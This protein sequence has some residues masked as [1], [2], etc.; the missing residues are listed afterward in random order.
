MENSLSIKKRVQNGETVNFS[1][2]RDI[3]HIWF[4]ER[5]KDFCLMLNSKVIK[6]T[7]T[8]KPVENKFNSIEP[9]LFEVDDE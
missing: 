9:E 8:F 1:N 6:A 3:V 7:K 4:S 2:D 5:S